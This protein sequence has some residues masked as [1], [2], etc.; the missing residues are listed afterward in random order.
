MQD[1][2]FYRISIF[3]CYLYLRLCSR[4][5]LSETLECLIIYVVQD[6][7]S[8]EMF[9]STISSLFWSILWIS[10]NKLQYLAENNNLIDFLKTSRVTL[11]VASKVMK[12]GQAL[13]YCS[14]PW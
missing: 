8:P 3:V 6:L 1:Y 7:E 12:I 14:M 2:T 5:Y 13:T 11:M 9:N 4:L 10:K